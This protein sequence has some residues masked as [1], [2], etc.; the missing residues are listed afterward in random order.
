MSC[1]PG[2]GVEARDMSDSARRDAEQLLAAANAGTPEHP[3]PAAPQ[4]EAPGPAEA[5]PE[6]PPEPEAET[7]EPSPE[8][9]AVLPPADPAAFTPPPSSLEDLAAASRSPKFSMSSRRR[10]K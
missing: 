5:E 9:E 8:P 1:W 7:E 10:G 3:E 6:P 2:R 4:A